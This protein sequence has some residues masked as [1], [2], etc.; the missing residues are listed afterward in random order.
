[1]DISGQCFFISINSLSYAGR[2]CYWPVPGCTCKDHGPVHAPPGMYPSWAMQGTTVYPSSVP[3]EFYVVN[4]HTWWY[5]ENFS[6][7]REF[8]GIPK[9]AYREFLGIPIAV[10]TCTGNGCSL[11]ANWAHK[12]TIQLVIKYVFRLIW[13]IWRFLEHMVDVLA[14]CCGCGQVAFSARSI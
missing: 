5:T 2:P 10:P 12:Q 13:V 1:M 11:F 7:Y 9:W 14:K 4:M 6:V 8:L 3:T